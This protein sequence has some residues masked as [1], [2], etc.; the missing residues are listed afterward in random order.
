M[1]PRYRPAMYPFLLA[2][3]LTLGPAAALS[4]QPPGEAPE[5]EGL[6]FFE[7]FIGVWLAH[8]DWEP[9]RDNPALAELVPLN[10][11]WGPAKRS[12]HFC[13]GLPVARGDFDACGLVIWNGATERAEFVAF[14][15][16][17]E[18]VFDGYYEM[19]APHTMRRIYDVIEPGGAV[20]T[21]RETF[22]LTP[23]GLIDWTTD[24]MEDGQWVR[25]RPNGPFFQ[26]IRPT[27]EPTGNLTALERLIGE[28]SP[29]PGRLP[30]EMI[31]WRRANGVT[32]GRTTFEWGTDRMWIEFVD[33]RLSGGE[34][35]REGSGLIAWD[36][37][38]QRVTYREHTNRET[39]LDGVVVVVD[40]L[41][42][43]R[44]YVSYAREGTAQRWVDRWRWEDEGAPCFEWTTIRVNG[45]EE[46]AW[47]PYWVCRAS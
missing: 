8:P 12:I 3:A 14:Q 2:L 45:D 25:R 17:G 15:G 47:P 41:T 38:R 31:E 18:L 29:D 6:S 40:D 42:I 24:R 4:Q 20:R 13:E 27:P 19:A 10:F 43:E 9:I 37:G 30:Q 16:S 21:Y 11:R 35:R 1:R 5:S 32:D 44:H 46:S 23:P 36:P 22:V 33:H 7:P 28:W 26:A 39:S 34:W